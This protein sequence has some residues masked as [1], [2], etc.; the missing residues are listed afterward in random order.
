MFATHKPLSQEILPVFYRLRKLLKSL[1]QIQRHRHHSRLC[2]RKER[3]PFPLSPALFGAMIFRSTPRLCIEIGCSI[4]FFHF[5]ANLSMAGDHRVLNRRTLRR[6]Q[7]ERLGLQVVLWFPGDL[8]VYKLFVSTHW[9]LSFSTTA[10]TCC[11]HRN[12]TYVSGIERMEILRNFHLQSKLSSIFD[13][14]R[15][16]YI[17][18]LSTANFY[19]FI[20][21]N[22]YKKE[23]WGGGRG[24]GRNGF[25]FFHEKWTNFAWNRKLLSYHE[26]SCSLR[27]FFF[28][29]SFHTHKT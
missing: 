3:H 12:A 1:R 19:H 27:A 6:L 11:W 29:R 14:S 20:C 18:V 4:S 9:N 25:S 22:S 16:H 10:A 15:F 8:N 28:T 24:G 23:E 5:F 26:K 7:R 13:V 2:T 17:I 21:S